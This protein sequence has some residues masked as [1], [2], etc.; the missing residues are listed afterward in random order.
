[1]IGAGA[2]YFTSY[3]SSSNKYKN[4]QGSSDSNHFVFS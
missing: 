1:V 2:P 3:S 4:E